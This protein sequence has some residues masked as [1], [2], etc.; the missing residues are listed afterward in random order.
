MHLPNDSKL[1]ITKKNSGA[2]SFDIKLAV[3]VEQASYFETFA[4]EFSKKLSFCR[5]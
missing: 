4:Q 5:Q 1:V 2:E 3:A